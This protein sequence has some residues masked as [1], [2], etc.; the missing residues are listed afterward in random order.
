MSLKV[1][2]AEDDVV[3]RR[4]I[5]EWLLSEGHE[6]VTTG[7]MTDALKA[8]NKQHF[9]AVIADVRLPDG[10]GRDLQQ[11]L[12]VRSKLLL[13][14]GDAPGTGNDWMHKPLSTTDLSRALRGL[15]PSPALADPTPAEDLPDIDDD[16]A[17]TA[18]GAGLSVLGGLRTLLRRELL[19]DQQ[20]LPQ[21]IDKNH[22]PEALE[23]LH[24]LKASSALCGLPRLR[25]ASQHLHE[26]IRSESLSAHAL[27]QWEEAVARALGRIKPG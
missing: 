10:D 23:L 25:N 6:C 9:D 24:K 11:H 13:M 18:L 1:L 4:Y 8:L 22:P 21:L 15:A 17:G 27:R 12:A 14:S 26:Q 7:N 16:A 3:N 5:S 20:Q 19:R 2:V